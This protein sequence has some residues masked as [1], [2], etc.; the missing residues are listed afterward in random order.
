[1]S[2]N[3]KCLH[4]S[5]L[6]HRPL[7]AFRVCFLRNGDRHFAGLNMAISMTHLKHFETLLEQVTVAMRRHVVLRSAITSILHIDG[8]ALTQLSGIGEGDML[9][10]CCQYEEMIDM[11]Y[12]VNKDFLR[13]RN[14]QN[15]FDGR[16]IYGDTLERV[17][18]TDLPEAIRQEHKNLQ[19]LVQNPRTVIFCGFAKITGTKRVVKMVNKQYMEHNSDDPYIEGEA[20]RILKSH[21]NI[22][23]MLYSVRDERHLYMVMEFL[24]WDVD[25]VIQVFG[26]MSVAN[27]R[28]VTKD[29]AEG[30]LYMRKKELVHRDIKPANL[31]IRYS[32]ETGVGTVK[33]T[34]FGMSAYYKGWK[35]YCCCGTP[36]YMAP[37]M[38]GVRGYDYQVDAWSLGVSLFRML[39]EELPYAY[40][41]QTL[42]EM[43]AAIMG[44]APGYPQEMVE[45][46]DPEA[47]ELM[48]ALLV[49]NP[50]S[51]LTI[52]GVVKHPFLLH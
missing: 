48:D 12:R 31:L 52:D 3:E 29:A 18:P 43:Y 28:K 50:R 37:E 30:L 24:E 1:M 42:T 23:E 11:E 40:S 46:T 2:A 34:D 22:V 5:R 32:C 36:G 20:L 38:I 14:L 35:L 15:R 7:K 44:S 10:C 16:R 27:A 45:H 41:Y 47:K 8:S 19:P 49:K 33:I 25:E 17:K 4:I 39:Y 21:P 26:P 9:I 6:H 13:L 51:R